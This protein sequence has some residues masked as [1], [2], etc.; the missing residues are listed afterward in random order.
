MAP[1]GRNLDAIA[2]VRHPV[3]P[4]HHAVHPL[5]A[6]LLAAALAGCVERYAVQPSAWRSRELPVALDGAPLRELEVQFYC[7]ALVLEPGPE[8]TCSLRVDLTAPDAEALQQLDQG[9]Q[10]Q[11][12]RAADGKAVLSIGLPQGA[13]LDA[14]HTFYRVQ[15]PKPVKVVVR[16]QCGAVSVRGFQGDVE[17]LGGSGGIDARLQGGRA[18]LQTTTGGIQLRGSYQIADLK[19]PQGRIDVQM[20]DTPLLALD[21]QV[22]GGKGDVFLDLQAGERVEL[23]YR[24]ETHAVRADPE[25][26]VE[27]DRVSVDEFH[28]GR[29]GD[30]DGLPAGSLQLISEGRVSV[31]LLPNGNSIP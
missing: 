19:S 11:L 16:T 9:L 8:P 20:P 28:L 24:G 26:R 5:L 29:I 18:M 31:R 1:A 30:P 12:Q 7:G 10:P 25:V 22:Q 6:L 3:R 21:L 13:P 15:A 17:V 23:R 27:W 14:I 2:A 4:V